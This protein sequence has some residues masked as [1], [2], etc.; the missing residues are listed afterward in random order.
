[1]L[2]GAKQV[3]NNLVE[4]AVAINNL[5]ELKSKESS[6]NPRQKIQF[7]CK[8]C[9]CTAERPLY[10]LQTGNY[11]FL[12]T[13][14][15]RTLSVKQTKLERYGNANFNNPEKN[16]QTNLKNHNG[17][18]NNNR[19][20]AEKTCLEKY[21]TKN[22]SSIDNVK[23]KKKQACLQRYGVDN[24]FKAKEIQEK[25]KQTNLEKFGFEFHQQADICKQKQK[26]TCLE[27]YG[28]EVP[29]SYGSEEFKEILKKKYGTANYHNIE[30]MKQTNLERYGAE[31][32]FNTD[33][34]KNKN[35]ETCLAKYGTEW[36]SQALSIREK[37]SETLK[38]TITKRTDEEWHQIRQKANKGYLYENLWFDSSWELALWIYAKDHNE[39]IERE[40]CAIDWEFK[41]KKH[42]YFPDFRYKGNLIEI[43]GDHFLTE[44]GTFQNPFQ[45][46]LNDVYEA[47]HQMLL[48]NNVQL[49][50]RKDVEFALDYVNQKYSK[51]YLK[52]F[53]KDLEYPYP[54][55]CKGDRDIINFFHKSLLEA[56]VKGKL[57]P[58]EA[59]Q[60]KNLIKKAA[61]NRLKYVHSCKP[62]DVARGMSVARIAPRVSVFKPNLARDLIEKYLSNFETIFDPFS[63]F[64]GRLIGAFR[65][66]KKYVGQDIH[67]KHVEE[68]NEIIKFLKIEN[69]TV[70]QQ[71]ILTDTQKS[72]DCLFTCPPYG[73]KEHWNKNNDEVEKSCD[74]WIDICLEKYKCKRYLFVVDQTEKYKDNV[75]EYLEKH[76]L[77]GK[78][79][80]LVILIDK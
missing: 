44:D 4:N 64:S 47:K 16:K 72:F 58:I 60:D 51:D 75:V 74:E 53:R 37:Q 50:L 1:M 8:L 41:N 18:Y 67:P 12:C 7:I 52:L 40:P 38:N 77:F 68:S 24:N 33:Y 32:I 70:T 42:K 21:G 57:S 76:S 71:D 48:A 3:M 23:E 45:P 78:S 65:N 25:T 43:K 29:H 59:W 56:S 49:W 66:N 19:Q 46:D 6:L 15:T 13:R 17:V 11:E 35:K 80:E 27:R 63:G 69:A 73:G 31:C 9:N 54:T 34:F 55:A 22:V 28:T 14:C 62:A 20:K 36:A 2:Q 39:E 10:R 26:Q 5:Q 79:P 30:K 61:L